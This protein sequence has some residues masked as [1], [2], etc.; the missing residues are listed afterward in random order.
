MDLGEGR[1][2][3]CGPCQELPRRWC[4][5]CAAWALSG[6]RWSRRSHVS[7]V[8]GGHFKASPPNE[9]VYVFSPSAQRMGFGPLFFTRI[10]EMNRGFDSMN[11][12]SKD[13][14]ANNAPQATIILSPRHG[15][16]LFF[17]VGGPCPSVDGRI[18]FRT[19]VQNLWFPMIPQ[20]KC[21]QTL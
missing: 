14:R 5:I 7:H 16:L 12:T 20:R 8:V 1:G 10:P 9:L 4:R 13:P 18:P 17:G 2:G 21:Q 15:N 11:H 6:Q 3:D 19:I